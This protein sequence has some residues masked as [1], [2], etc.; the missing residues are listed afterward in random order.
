MIQRS[1]NA[2]AFE[3]A[4]DERGVLLLHGFSGTPAEVRDLGVRLHR[5][6]YGVSGP[7]LPGHAGEPSELDEI[8]VDDYLRT[9]EAAFDAVRERYRVVHVVGFSMGGALGLYLAQ[10]RRMNA[11]V[12]INAPIEMPQH[13][14]R[15]VPFVAKINRNAPLPVNPRALFG[16]PG[17]PAMPAHSVA[18]FLDVLE[19][20]RAGLAH[21]TC[22]LLV[23]HGAGDVTVPASNAETIVRASG[24]H[25]RSVIVPDAPHLM[26]MG[27]W[28]DTIEPFI[29]RFLA[30]AD[31]GL[32]QDGRTSAELS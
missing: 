3:F 10:N 12:T 2:D 19:H 15:S 22:P 5:L 13:V 1:P 17:Y 26:T 20:V 14:R 6:G 24:A 4:G 8:R 30:D 29:A 9:V 27:R 31:R 23:L 16:H 21:L 18:T 32:P 7:T 25:A 28:L 11:L